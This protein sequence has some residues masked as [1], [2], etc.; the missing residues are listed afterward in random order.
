[1]KWPKRMT[2][3]PSPINHGRMP[4]LILHSFVLFKWTSLSIRTC[5]DNQKM[6]SSSGPLMYLLQTW[7]MCCW[8]DGFIILFS[9]R[10]YLRWDVAT[11]KRWSHYAGKSLS[12][13]HQT[14]PGEDRAK[15]ESLL[16]SRRHQQVDW[17][18]SPNRTWT[19]KMYGN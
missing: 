5:L 14:G 1:M 13:P 2:V 10:N 16:R 7:L 8:I 17:L 6:P 3:G 18:A 19:W 15:V 4:G 12:Y 11:S 9:F